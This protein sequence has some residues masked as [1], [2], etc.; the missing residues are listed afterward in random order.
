MLLMLVLFDG[1]CLFGFGL[2]Y[3]VPQGV[4]SRNGW[5]P[6]GSVGS[7]VQSILGADRPWRGRG[8]GVCEQAL[9]PWPASELDLIWSWFMLVSPAFGGWPNPFV[10]HGDTPLS[11]V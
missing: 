1:F 9:A 5:A 6:G 2:W 8:G 4:G 7:V 10:P 3:G 11:G